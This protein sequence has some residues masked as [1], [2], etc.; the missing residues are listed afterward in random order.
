MCL[1]AEKNDLETVCPIVTIKTS[2]SLRIGT[3]W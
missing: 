3:G 2:K 1:Q